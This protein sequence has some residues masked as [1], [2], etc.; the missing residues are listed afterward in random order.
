MNG[1]RTLFE[2]NHH[3]DMWRHLTTTRI[4]ELERRRTAAMRIENQKDRQRR[5]MRFVRRFIEYLLFELLKEHYS[6]L[7]GRGAL[8][9][10]GGSC[11]PLPPPN[12]APKPLPHLIPSTTLYPVQLPV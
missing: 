7:L 4:G 11:L 9:R 3:S 10:L 8:D 2:I 1:D 5:Q 12:D 6:I